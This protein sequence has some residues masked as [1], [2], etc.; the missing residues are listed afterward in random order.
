M[1]PTEIVTR[2][3]IIT[4]HA[5]SLIES[6]SSYQHCENF[7]D[8]RDMINRKVCSVFHCNADVTVVLCRSLADICFMFSTFD[9]G[10]SDS[11]TFF[12]S[13]YRHNFCSDFI[14]NNW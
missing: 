6:E 4:L 5:P 13:V 9:E 11:W 7:Q 8:T 2:R 12:G 1:L 14:G 3:P 10:N